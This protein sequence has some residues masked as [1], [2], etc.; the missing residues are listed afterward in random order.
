MHRRRNEEGGDSSETLK[1][2]MFPSNCSLQLAFVNSSPAILSFQ[3]KKESSPAMMAAGAGAAA[4]KIFFAVGNLLG[5][6][7]F[8]S[9]FRIYLLRCYICCSSICTKIMAPNLDSIW[10]KK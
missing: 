8:S 2:D 6:H 5:Q 3:K 4:S 10:R 1:A 7:R 9:S